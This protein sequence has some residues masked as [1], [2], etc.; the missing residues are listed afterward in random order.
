M[1]KNTRVFDC[2]KIICF[3][4]NA[5]TSEIA[6]NVDVDIRNFRK[7]LKLIKTHKIDLVIVGLKNLW[8]EELSIS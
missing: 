7:I 2:K 3:P 5:G 6:K 1:Q 8:S 4:G